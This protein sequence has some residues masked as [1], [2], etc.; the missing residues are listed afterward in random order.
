MERSN[1]KEEKEFPRIPFSARK[2]E[3]GNRSIIHCWCN[4]AA[5]RWISYNNIKRSWTVSKAIK[6]TRKIETVRGKDVAAQVQDLFILASRTQPDGE[7]GDF[8]RLRQLI[9]AEHAAR[10]HLC[11]CN[12]IRGSEKVNC[13]F[14][15]S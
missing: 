9:D 5:P 13:L 7:F 12:D 8:R 6:Q 4:V 3:V 11:L 1:C 15:R 2:T 10:Q 14:L